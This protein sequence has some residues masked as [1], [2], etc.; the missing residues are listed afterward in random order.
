MNDWNSKPLVKYASMSTMKAGASLVKQNISSPATGFRSITNNPVCWM[1]VPSC[2]GT[3][4]YGWQDPLPD[5]SKTPTSAGS[6]THYEQV[7][8]SPILEVGAFIVNTTVPAANS[9]TTCTVTTPTGWTMA[10]SPEN[11]GAFPTSFFPG[12]DGTLLDTQCQRRC[13]EWH[14]HTGDCDHQ[15]PPTGS[16]GRRWN[17]SRQPDYGRQRRCQQGQSSGRH[18]G[19]TDHLDRATLM[20]PS[21]MKTHRRASGFTLVELMVTIMIG[22]ILV[23]VAVPGFLQQIRKSRR[24]DAKTAILD[25]ASREERL[26]STTNTYSADAPTMGY[27]A[28]GQPIGSGYY[29][30]DVVAPAAPIR[31]PLR[32]PRRRSIRR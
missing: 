12:P 1:D 17:L 23:T 13:L 5:T 3:P 18:Q 29:K 20:R 21:N 8:Y 31:P 28:F 22:A 6:T 10:I 11:G 14:R 9:P 26:F 2:A 27:A 25:L 16:A 7:I 32:L 4:Q 15:R 24:T 30:L 19:R